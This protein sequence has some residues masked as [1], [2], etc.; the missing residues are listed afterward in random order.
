M[1]DSR[2]PG[3][4]WVYAPELHWYGWRTLIPLYRG[5]DEYARRTLV[6]GWT[7]TGRIVIAYRG[8]GDPECVADMYQWM[9]D[10]E[11]QR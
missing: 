10:E 8:C 5:H 4:V 9:A 1:T 3:R 2:K 11:A 6:I 7:V